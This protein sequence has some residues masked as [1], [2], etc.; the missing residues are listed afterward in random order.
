VNL[1]IAAIIGIVVGLAIVTYSLVKAASRKPPTL[2][3]ISTALLGLAL[4]AAWI[5]APDRGDTLL[6]LLG[7]ALGALA[8]GVSATFGSHKDGD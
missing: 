7:T 6:P 3:I 4:V 5:A 8:A 1:S 2:V